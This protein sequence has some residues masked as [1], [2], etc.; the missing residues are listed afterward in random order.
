MKLEPLTRNVIA[1]KKEIKIKAKVILNEQHS[2][3]PDQERVL[4]EKFGVGNWETLPIPA[5]GWTLEDM[6][7]VAM[8]FQGEEVVFA[9]PVPVL[10]KWLS[11]AVESRDTLKAWGL[12]LKHEVDVSC[13]WVFHNDR[14]KAR[15]VTLND[16]QK[17][18]IHSVAET[19]WKLV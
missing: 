9:S 6:D 1:E 14:R 4:D 13:V 8:S 17:R 12:N 15:E 7:N 5:S 3:L 10:I 19:G 2:L 16:G 11:G 18:I